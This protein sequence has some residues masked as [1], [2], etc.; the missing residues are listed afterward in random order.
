MR[1]RGGVQ[2]KEATTPCGV[3]LSALDAG[4]KSG[5][6]LVLLC[7]CVALPN[8]CVRMWAPL[9]QMHGTSTGLRTPPTAP[10]APPRPGHRL[11]GG[12]GNP[13]PPPQHSGPDSTPKAFPYPNTRPNRISNRQ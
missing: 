2:V 1:G 11:K 4:A 7:S 12:G 6:K 10:G 9:V 13:L 3:L 5:Q 8:A